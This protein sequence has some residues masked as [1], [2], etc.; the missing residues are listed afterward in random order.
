VWRPGP[1]GGWSFRDRAGTYGGIVRVVLKPLAGGALEVKVKGRRRDYART[2]DMPPFWAS[3]AVVAS[4]GEAQCSETA[5]SRSRC[6]FAETS[7]TLRCSPLPPQRR[8]QESPDALVRCTIR[9]VV[10]AEEAYYAAH[11]TYFGG[12]CDL[13]PGFELPPD[14]SCVTSGTDLSLAVTT[15][16]PYADI[17]CVYESSPSPGYSNLVCD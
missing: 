5:L 11:G 9:N 4:G 1:R 16:S 14:V 6:R 13:L 7:R 17:A 10:A 8:C 15:A 2:T 3:V 12:P